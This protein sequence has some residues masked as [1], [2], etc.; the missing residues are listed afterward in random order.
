M[1][2][3]S[4]HILYKAPL[5]KTGYTGKPY[6]SLLVAYASRFL[7]RPSTVAQ[8]YLWLPT[9][10]CAASVCLN[11]ALYCIIGTLPALSPGVGGAGVIFAGDSNSNFSWHE[12]PRNYLRLYQRFH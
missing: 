7:I 3:S 9:P 4:L 11:K 6:F 5:E 12:L 1:A 8:G 10:C 2:A